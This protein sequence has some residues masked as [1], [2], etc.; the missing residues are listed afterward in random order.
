MLR[1]FGQRDQCLR[2]NL[3]C[4]GES[5]DPIVVPDDSVWV[6]VFDP[7]AQEREAV[8]AFIG[9]ETPSKDDMDEIE[10][11]SRLYQED[12]AVFMTALVLSKTETVESECQAVSFILAGDRLFVAL[13]VCIATP[14]F[15]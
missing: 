13:V 12:D 4:S 10:I 9:V 14:S 8:K 3:T 2:R 5:G 1:S 6:D 7:T 11:S 15:T